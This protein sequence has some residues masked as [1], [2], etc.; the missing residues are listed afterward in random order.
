MSLFLAL[1]PGIY[2]TIQAIIFLSIA[3]LIGYWIVSLINEFSMSSVKRK[4]SSLKRDLANADPEGNGASQIID[5][6]GANKERLSEMRKQ[7]LIMSIILFLS[8]T[9]VMMT[10][11]SGLV[12]VN[13]ARVG[14]CR[15]VEDIITIKTS[16]WTI[17][18]RRRGNLVWPPG[19]MA[20]EI[21]KTTKK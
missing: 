13:E 10:D 3:Y 11:K 1:H 18:C 14:H 7:Y 19:N 6:I 17:D 12:V 8:F 16:T 15:I 20:K 9:T 5:L 4:I 2:H 21:C